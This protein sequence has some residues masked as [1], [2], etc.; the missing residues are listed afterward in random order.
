MMTA[1]TGV[2]GFATVEGLNIAYEAAGTGTPAVLF[3]H[4]AFEDHSYF[5][6]QVTHLARGQRVVSLDL[7]GH[8]ESARQRR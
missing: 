2:T 5:A 4:G 8:G 1:G 6:P 3:I 7:R